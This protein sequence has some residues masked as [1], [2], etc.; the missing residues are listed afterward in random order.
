MKNNYDLMIQLIRLFCYVSDLYHTTLKHEVQRFSPNAHPKFSDEEA[1]STYLW[2][3][4]HGHLNI[5]A[6]HSFI[7]DYYYDCFPMLPCYQEYVR[8]INLLSPAFSALAAVLAEKGLMLLDAPFESLLDSF[9]I[10][11]ANGR[12]MKQAK[13]ARECCSE[14]YCSSKNMHYYGVKLHVS[15]FRRAA[16][17]PIPEHMLVTQA[18]VH[19][20]TAMRHVLETTP[21]RTFYADKAYVSSDLNRTMSIQSSTIITPSKE[22]KGESEWER[23]FNR[24]TNN[25]VQTAV[26]RIRQPIEALFNW[27]EQKVN[28]QN[29]SRVR[30]TPGLYVFIFARLSFC[31]LLLLRFF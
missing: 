3:I 11:L 18:S 26:S 2:G 27:L 30:S 31:I 1:I 9:P 13:V 10:I 8:R 23:H 24:A 20:L 22:R 29:A 12:R 21:N 5:K 19:D 17:L 4:K 7:A 14:G 15:G 25:L 16:A 6:I 28:L